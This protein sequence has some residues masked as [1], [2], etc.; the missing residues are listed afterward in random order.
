MRIGLFLLSAICCTCSSD[1]THI[2]IKGSDTE[3]NLVVVLAEECYE[4][5]KDILISVS[6]GGSG[7]GIASLLNGILMLPI[8]P[9]VLIRKRLSYLSKKIYN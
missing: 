1:N 2:K 6:G 4:M 9:E 5:N 7:L 8:L 3:V